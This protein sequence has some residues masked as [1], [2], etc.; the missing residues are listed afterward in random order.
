MTLIGLWVSEHSNVFALASAV[1]V[2]IAEV[3]GL[4]YNIF[5]KNQSIRNYILFVFVYSLSRVCFLVWTII[6]I[7]QV[8]FYK[9]RNT[10][11]VWWAP[12]AGVVMQCT[13]LFINLRFLLTHI[14]KLLKI[15]N[16]KSN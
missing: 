4:M 2:T 11:V 12:V 7:Y 15:L 16:D 13:I 5:S 6:F 14:R 8:I 1:S 9:G 3:G 10:E